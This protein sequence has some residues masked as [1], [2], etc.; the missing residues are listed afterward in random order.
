MNN[1]FSLQKMSGT[2]NLD[3]S[4]VSRHHKLN[5]LA[6]FKQLKYENPKLKQ[7]EIASQL[8]YS[9]STLQRYRN[10]KNLL[11]LQRIRADTTNKLIKKASYT[12]FDNNSNGDPDVKRPQMTS[13]DLAIPET[14]TKSIEKNR[15]FLKE[16]EQILELLM[17]K[18]L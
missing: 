12:N 1:T 5:Q 17:V 7:S 6:D 15:K 13:K 16:K 18:M 8:G 2:S 10:V 3:A 14:N 4:L 11:L 9:S